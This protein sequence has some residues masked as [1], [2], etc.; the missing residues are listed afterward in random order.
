[1]LRNGQNELEISTKRIE[2]ILIHK[3]ALADESKENLLRARAYYA[4]Y[5][6]ASPRG[7]LALTVVSGR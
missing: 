6:G 3:I 5:L 7:S 1:M 4:V 2:D